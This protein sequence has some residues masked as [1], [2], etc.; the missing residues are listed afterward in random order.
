[1]S[2]NQP[3]PPPTPTNQVLKEVSPAERVVNAVK[4]SEQDVVSYTG[5]ADEAKKIAD[6]YSRTA[7]V[8]EGMGSLTQASRENTTGR[9]QEIQKQQQEKSFLSKALSKLTGEAG[10]AQAEEKNL[11]AEIAR[12]KE[13]EQKQ[14]ESV[15]EQ[16]E[17]AKQEGEFSETKIKAATH[18]EVVADANKLNVTQEEAGKK[19]WE[20]RVVPIQTSPELTQTLNKQDE[21][22]K[23]LKFYSEHKYSAEQPQ[24]LLTSE[25]REELKDGFLKQRGILGYQQTIFII[26]KATEAKRTELNE[27][28]K[29]TNP[30]PERLKKL[31]NTLIEQEDYLIKETGRVNNKIENKIVEITPVYEE[32]VK[33]TDEENI[34]VSQHLVTRAII[35]GFS[36]TADQNMNRGEELVKEKKGYYSSSDTGYYAIGAANLKEFFERRKNI[37]EKNRLPYI[38]AYAAGALANGAPARMVDHLRLWIAEN[39]PVAQTE[40]VRENGEWVDKISDPTVLGFGYFIGKSLY[41]YQERGTRNKALVETITKG[42]NIAMRVYDGLEAKYQYDMVNHFGGGYGRP[43]LK[44]P[45]LIKE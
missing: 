17:Q 21:L 38:I 31:K 16:K 15:V 11:L 40:R 41:D 23:T 12:L 7:A 36:I 26:T 13:V 22:S 20:E 32:I 35:E 33:L 27:Y 44:V 37:P 42:N 2:E 24:Y 8:Q 3:S 6:L 39:T 43:N 45:Q 1:M 19:P 34:P 18:S 4:R 25:I 29:L 5:Q 10:T 14:A 9:L 28:S 30:D